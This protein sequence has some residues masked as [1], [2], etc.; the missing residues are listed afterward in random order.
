MHKLVSAAAIA[1]PLLG[2]ALLADPVAAR[3]LTVVPAGSFGEFRAICD[4]RDGYLSV[5]NHR[6][7]CELPSGRVL[8]LKLRPVYYDY[9]PAPAPGISISIFD[10]PHCKPEK[11]EALIATMGTNCRPDKM[12]PV[13]Q[14][15]PVLKG[16][17]S[18]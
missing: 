17:Y 4:D 3:Q 10:H 9:Y 16:L 7:Y 11:V 14:K 2:S 8:T 15:Q 18:R 12:K 1:L 6:A 5:S 13:E